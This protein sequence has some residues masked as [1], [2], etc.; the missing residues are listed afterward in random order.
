MDRGLW[1]A[2]VHGVAKSQTQLS[3]SHFHFFTFLNLKKKI[4]KYLLVKGYDR[5]NILSNDQ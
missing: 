5:K 4:P 2:T 1:S 3:D